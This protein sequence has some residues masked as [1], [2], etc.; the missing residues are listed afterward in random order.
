MSVNN[1]VHETQQAYEPMQLQSPY[2]DE[3]LLPMQI[4]EGGGNAQS[5]DFSAMPAPVRYFGYAFLGLML[6]FVL[7]VVYVSM[8]R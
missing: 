6:S 7:A 4:I 1:K 3:G 8:F 5:A 2:V